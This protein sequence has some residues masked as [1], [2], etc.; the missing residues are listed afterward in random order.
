MAAGSWGVPSFQCGDTLI[1][2]Q[3]RLA[4]VEQAIKGGE[5]LTVNNEQ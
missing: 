3:D 5:E 4:L 2:G 1:W